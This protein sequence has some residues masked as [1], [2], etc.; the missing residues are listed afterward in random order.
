[1][2]VNTV[3]TIPIF[4]DADLWFMNIVLQ[5]LS[6]KEVQNVFLIVRKHFWFTKVEISIWMS[7]II[8]HETFNRLLSKFYRNHGNVLSLI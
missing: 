8:S 2:G 5:F 3:L 1:M 6:A 7:A 4:C